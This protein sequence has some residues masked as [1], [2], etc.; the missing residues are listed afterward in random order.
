MSDF[1]LGAVRNADSVAGAFGAP[2]AT[3]ITWK[4]HGSCDGYAVGH[5][6]EREVHVASWAF[7]VIL[8]LRL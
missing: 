7:A 6:I 2:E 1:R 5:G 4:S 3:E 8:A